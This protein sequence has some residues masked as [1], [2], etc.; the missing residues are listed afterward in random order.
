MA[1]AYAFHLSQAQAFIEGNKRTGIAAALIFLEYN[2]IRS[3]IDDGTL[4]DAMLG[5]AEHRLNK[6]Q[7]AAILRSFLQR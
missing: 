1:A 3:R 2:G 7:L 6:P 5:I 4:Y